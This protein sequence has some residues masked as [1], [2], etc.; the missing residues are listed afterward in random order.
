M[1]KDQEP[2]EEID[3]V[4][5]G[6]C[7]RMGW[8]IG[9]IWFEFFVAQAWICDVFSWSGRQKRKEANSRVAQWV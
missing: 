5:M 3:G 6:L 4:K 8:L 7:R 2:V 1:M 9:K